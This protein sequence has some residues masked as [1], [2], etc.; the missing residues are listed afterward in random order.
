MSVYIAGWSLRRFALIEDRFVLETP[1]GGLASVLSRLK[2]F[3]AGQEGCSL[4]HRVSGARDQ[5]RAIFLF[6]VVLIY[7]KGQGVRV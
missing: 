5:F 2:F 3:S 4:R 1:T 7:L 6:V